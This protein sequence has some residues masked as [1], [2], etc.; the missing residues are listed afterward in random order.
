MVER[1]MNDFQ[2]LENLPKISIITPSYQQGEFIEATLQSVISQNYPSLEYIVI[3]GGSSDNSV[4]IIR[5]YESKITHWVSERDK[6]Q[7]DALNK[8]FKSAT[9]D[10]IGWINSDDI[11]V[12]DA[13]LK[14]GTFFANHPDIS[15]VYGDALAID[16]QGNPLFL[17]E[18]GKFDIR[19]LIRTDD[20]PQSSVFFR[21]DFLIAIGYLDERLHYA[22]DYDL[23]V[24]ASLKQVP[25]YIPETLSAFRIY[26]E[27]KTSEGKTPFSVDIVYFIDQILRNSHP[28]DDQKISLLTTQFWRTFEILLARET[29]KM[30]FT[31]L[32]NDVTVIQVTERYVDALYPHFLEIMR[33]PFSVTRFRM[34]SILSVA[35]SDLLNQYPDGLSLSNPGAVEKLVLDQAL[36]MLIFSLRLWQ[37]NKR[38]EALRLFSH[39][40]FFLP[41]LLANPQFRKILKL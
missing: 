10:I 16:R 32:K 38:K 19:W 40:C 23:L 35:M 12:P 15:L 29:G 34:Q 36:D 1:K 28:N 21:R 11:L 3:D 2:S 14:V 26:P 9:G 20:I 18:P 37:V 13:L 6:G 17:R 5:C 7:T 24:K 41:Q 27:T 33:I 8:G 4:D 30:T 22:L 39:T 31:D 25:G